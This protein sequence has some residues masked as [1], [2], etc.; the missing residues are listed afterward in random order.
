MTSLN[1]TPEDPFGFR[2]EPDGDEW[3]WV[4]LSDET[5]EG[6]FDSRE[7]AIEGAVEDAESPVPQRES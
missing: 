4:R 6:G 2:I 1:D 3:R 7:A 5:T